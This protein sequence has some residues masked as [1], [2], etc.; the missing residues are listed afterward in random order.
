MTTDSGND[1]NFKMTLQVLNKDYGYSNWKCEWN[2]WQAFNSLENGKEEPAVLSLN[3]QNKPAVWN[4]SIENFSS[5]NEVNYIITELDKL[6]M[7]DGSSIA[8]EIFERVSRSTDMLIN[9]Y[10]IKF[11]D[12]HLIAKRHKI[13]VLDEVLAT[14][15]L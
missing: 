11:E 7:K 12:L 4:I 1:N 8:Y 14:W 5:I 9:D 2:I 13:Q 3:D 10:V 15:P 6:F